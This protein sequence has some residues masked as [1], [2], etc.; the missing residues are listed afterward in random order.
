MTDFCS[1]NTE[2]ITDSNYNNSYSS[3]G[4]TSCLPNGG[5]GFSTSEN[6]VVNTATVDA[7]VVTLLSKK[8]AVAPDVL[9]PRDTRPAQQY[10]TNSA[11]LRQDILN[12][13]CF[14]YKRYIYILNDI[15]MIAA[16]TNKNNL[17]SDY[18][19]KK[20]NTEL[21][22]SKLNQILQ[23]LQSLN[24]SR[25]NSLKSYYNI[26][27]GINQLNS[28]LD[29][30]RQQLIE[31]SRILK[32]ASMEKD[33]KGAMVDYTIEKNSSSR[34]LLAIYGFMNI[35]AISLIFYLYRSVKN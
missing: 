9:L 26:D 19:T 34:N 3:T 33:I 5:S 17:N 10:A 1:G 23:I 32:N 28:E 21:L 30:T 27:K 2:K 4:K 14:Y 16:T 22:N 29:T 6:G 31:H 8:N 18:T 12:E 15:L 35:V 20:S 13:Y 25:V 24:N 7:H 11:A